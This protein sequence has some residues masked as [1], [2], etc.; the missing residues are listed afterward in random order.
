MMHSRGMGVIRPKLIKKR[1]GNEPVK[2][3]KEGGEEIL[4]GKYK[5]QLTKPSWK[6]T[7]KYFRNVPQAVW[8]GIENMY[9]STEELESLDKDEITLKEAFQSFEKQVE[10]LETI[11]GGLE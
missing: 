7:D 8:W 1:D 11:L 3:Y 2:I 4:V 9:I 6:P 10:L 5:G